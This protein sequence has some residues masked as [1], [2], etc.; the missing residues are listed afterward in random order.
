MKLL[1]L[2]VFFAILALTNLSG[3]L[4]ALALLDHS[5][6]ELFE[7]SPG[8]LEYMKQAQAPIPVPFHLSRKATQL[9]FEVLA[10]AKI[11]S[12]LIDYI[13]MLPTKM[14]YLSS[15]QCV[16]K[17]LREYQCDA[18]E[19]NLTAASSETHRKLYSLLSSLP[20]RYVTRDIET[21]LS[22]CGHSFYVTRT[23]FSD[24]AQSHLAL[25]CAERYTGQDKSLRSCE[26]SLD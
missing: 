8:Q 24:R 3:S 10:E 15:I 11:P 21:C 17:G 26:I 20:S 22:G 13:G 14:Y 4:S 1:K 16:R 19:S 6:V 25:K 2:F 18:L 23:L 7:I 12:Y 5:Q 9:A